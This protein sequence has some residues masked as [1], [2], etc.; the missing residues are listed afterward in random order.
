MPWALSDIRSEVR[1]LTGRLSSNQLSTNEIDTEINN[2][3]Q[4]QFPAEVK[5]ERKHTW[6]E[7]ETVAN[8]Q[9]YEFP[10]GF[11]SFEPP[12]YLN[13]Q[14]LLYYQDPT[15]YFAENPEQIN[16]QTPWTGDGTTTAF[17][18]T[19]Q[20]PYILPNSVIV[21]DNVETFN[22][23]GNGNLVGDQG[24]TGTVNYTTGAIAVNFNTAPTDGQTIYVTFEQYMPGQPTAVLAYDN[25]W[26]FYVVPNTVY[27]VRIKA[28]SVPD[29]LELATDTPTLEEWGPAIALG[30]ARNI[31][32]KKGENDLYNVLTAQ[33]K[34]QI[35]YILTRTVQNL[36]NTRSQPSW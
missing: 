15:V 17:A 23:D 35:S 14:P 27:G 24:G 10:D 5:L 36:M 8:Q 31:V 6:Y 21:T 26:R 22:D 18:T 20:F 33:Y 11:T 1:Q 34:E 7:F 19:I 16:Q 32:R 13:L 2:Y 12:M 30:A 28:Y 25:K 4:F 9:E 3:Y 29:P